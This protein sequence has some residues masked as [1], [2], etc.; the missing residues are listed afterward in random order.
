MGSGTFLYRYLSSWNNLAFIT[1]KLG[2]SPHC[3][4]HELFHSIHFEISVDFVKCLVDSRIFLIYCTLSRHFFTLY[5]DINDIQLI[6]SCLR[7]KP[8][9]GSATRPIGPEKPCYQVSCLQ[10]SSSIG[11][12]RWIYLTI[13]LPSTQVENTRR[14]S[15]RKLQTRLT[16]NPNLP[17]FYQKELF[18]RTLIHLF[19]YFSISYLPC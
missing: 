16:S 5:S 4:G 11:T 17:Y 8:I 6:F 14:H 7:T 19:I 12:T 1:P 10:W 3:N 2:T 9:L 18:R 13:P 15:F